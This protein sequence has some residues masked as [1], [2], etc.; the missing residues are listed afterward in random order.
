MAEVKNLDLSL[1]RVAF[2]P[3][4]ITVDRESYLISAL[5][6]SLAFLIQQDSVK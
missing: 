6:P 2:N 3:A 5:L 1:F 4:K